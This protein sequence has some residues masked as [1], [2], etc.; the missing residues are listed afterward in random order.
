M[1]L[2][3]PFLVTYLVDAKSRNATRTADMYEAETVL[4]CAL[5]HGV[6]SKASKRGKQNGGQRDV[7]VRKSY[8]RALLTKKV[9]SEKPVE[10]STTWATE[11]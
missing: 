5:L 1:H 9:L 10:G 2:C 7:L 4:S 6:V 11:Q 8:F 3:Y